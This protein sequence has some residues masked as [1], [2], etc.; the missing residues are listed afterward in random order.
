[1]SHTALR[2][3]MI[4]LLHDPTF[5]AAL[6]ADPDQALADVALEP[7]ERRLLAAVPEAAWRTDPDRPGRVLAALADELPIATRL[8]PARAAAFLGSRHFHEAVQKRGSLALAYGA[9]LADDPEPRVVA[10]ARLE[11]AVASVRREPSPPAPSPAGRLRLTPLGRLVRVRAGALDLLRALREGDPAG[12]ALEPG[13]ETVLVLRR[14]DADDVGLEW[15]A[16]ELEVLLERAA[17]PER[18]ETLDAAARAVGADGSLAVQ[19]VDG[20]VADGIL[21]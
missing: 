5:V 8:A 20:L 11:T 10:L 1:M 2:R 13:H 6:R 16:P 12:R 21:V 3:V 4:R 15:L 19:V 14:P 17:R 9:H 18:R 7:D